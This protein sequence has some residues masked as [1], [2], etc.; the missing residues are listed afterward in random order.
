[1]N[2]GNK[3]NTLIICPCSSLFV[4]CC[5]EKKEKYRLICTLIESEKPCPPAWR[6]AKKPIFCETSVPSQTSLSVNLMKAFLSEVVPYTSL[7]FLLVS[8]PLPYT[9]LLS[10]RWGKSCFWWDADLLELS[11]LRLEQDSTVRIK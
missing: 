4:K 7:L 9:F 10:E 5:T 6:W 3:S 8:P 11:M 1:M 2:K